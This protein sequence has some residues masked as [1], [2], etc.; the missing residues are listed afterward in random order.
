[1]R[2]VHEESVVAVL[3]FRAIDLESVVLDIGMSAVSDPTRS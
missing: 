1:M 3:P 2:Y